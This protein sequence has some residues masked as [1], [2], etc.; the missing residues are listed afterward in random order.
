MDID[1]KSTRWSWS[2]LILEYLGTF[3]KYDAWEM[4]RYGSHMLKLCCDWP[5]RLYAAFHSQGGLQLLQFCP[6]ARC[7]PQAKD[8]FLDCVTS[9]RSV[10]HRFEIAKQ[11]IAILSDLPHLAWDTR[12]FINRLGLSVL[13]YVSVWH[14]F[15]PPWHHYVSWGFHCHA[16]QWCVLPQIHRLGWILKA[17]ALYC[18]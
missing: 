18:Q 10:G 16:L 13:W 4:L 14:T 3:F 8:S 7:L 5:L 17:Y 11:T 9:Q 2:W 15:S 6:C 12:V 1:R